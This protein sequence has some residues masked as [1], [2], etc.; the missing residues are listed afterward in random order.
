MTDARSTMI[1]T[2][3]TVNLFV[4]NHLATV[5]TVPLSLLNCVMFTL[6]PEG[7][8]IWSTLGRRCVGTRKTATQWSHYSS[9]QFAGIQTKW[10]WWWSMESRGPFAIW[11]FI[12]TLLP[13]VFASR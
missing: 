10:H 8:F 6:L 11:I 1:V 12:Q 2:T 3:R 9:R 7:R 5:V 13:T 4:R